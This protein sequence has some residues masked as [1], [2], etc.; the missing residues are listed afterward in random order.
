[1]GMNMDKRHHLIVDGYNVILRSH[2]GLSRDESQLLQGRNRLLG[3]LNAYGSGKQ[4]RTTVVFD[5]QTGSRQETKASSAGVRILFS[6]PPQK[7]DQVI[8]QLLEKEPNARNVTLVTSDQALASLARSMGCRH[9][10]AEQ[11]MRK[12]ASPPA[13]L[14]YREKYD[15][16]LSQKDMDQWLRLFE[17]SDDDS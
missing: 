15:P 14:D 4:L 17:N 12:L 9:W 16:P 5:G 2:K 7:A 11:F 3:R 13:D 1:M 10:T 8:I 6:Q